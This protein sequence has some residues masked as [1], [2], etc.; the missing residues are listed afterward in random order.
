MPIERRQTPRRHAG[1]G[2]VLVASLV[3]C[4]GAS[5]NSR[6]RSPFAASA[7]PAPQVLAP[8]AT[9]EQVVAAV[10]AN[11]ARV[12]TYVTNSASISVPGGLATPRLRGNIAVER[13]RR[14]RLRAGTAITGPEVDLG[15]NDE[16]YWLWSKRNDPP[17]VFFARHA[18]HAGSVAQQFLPIEPEWLLDA[19]GLLTLDPN[20]AYQGPMPRPDGTLEIRMTEPS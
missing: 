8:T 18:E 1:F 5:C 15:S 11:T 6:F 14:L 13:P 17:A 10:N 12:Q 9:I 16:L 4:S 7:S 19:L 20:A 2:L 3:A